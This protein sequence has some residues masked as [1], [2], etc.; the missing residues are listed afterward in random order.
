VAAHQGGAPMAARARSPHQAPGSP[1]PD[2]PRMGLG[3][4]RLRVT[5]AL[6]LALTVSGLAS[7]EG[8]ALLQRALR[9]PSADDIA[10]RICTAYLAQ[11]Y[12]LLASQIDP[13]TIAPNV[14]APW[15]AHAQAALLEQLHTEDAA[16]GRVTHCAYSALAFGAGPR[17]ATTRQYLFSM[18]R[19]KPYSTGMNLN[20][21]ADG[22]WL[23]ARDSDFLGVPAGA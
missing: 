4:L 19:A 21:Q 9:T 17:P 2:A 14:T 11:N 22:G 15:D 16:L 8:A 20:R 7:A 23:I 6:L 13:A 1:A 3:R 12:D 10:Q 5:L 18:Q